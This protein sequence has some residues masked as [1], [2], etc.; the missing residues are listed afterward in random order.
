MNV[1]IGAGISGL[2]AGQELRSDFLILEKSSALGGLAGQYRAG[3]F[4]FDHGGH[5]FHFQDKPEIQRHVE[6]FHAFRRYRRNSK[7][8]L[9]GRFIPYS[10]QY[11]LAG[12]PARQRN[13]ILAEVL[14][15]PGGPAG[16]PAQ[17]L[18]RFL[19]AHFGPSLVRLFFAPYLEK[20]YGR[21]LAAMIAGMDKGSIPVPRKEDVVAGALCRRPCAEGYNPVF[22]YPSGSLQAFIDDYGRP[23]AARIRC[24]EEVVA[25]EPARKLVVTNGGSYRYDSL[26]STMPLN[27]LL[28]IM[29]PPQPFPRKQFHHLSTLVVNAVLARRRRRFH[30]LY[31]PET[32]FPFYRVGYYPAAG[33]VAVYLEKTI[34]AD[35]PLDARQVRREAVFTLKRTGMI[36]GAEE[37]LF[38]DLKRI[39]VS[40]VVFDR[41]WP[42]LVPAALAHLRRQS[43]HSIGRYGSWN[44]TSMA[45]DI[46]LAR[47][48]AGRLNKA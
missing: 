2:S 32:Q 15:G 27:R 35:S 40:Y 23:L 30:W 38:H 11:H 1:I 18:E 7:V 13:P 12:L 22:Y 45:D 20:F 39:P 26:I 25:I 16:G 29:T 14:A 17:D 37:I 9:Q 44:Y 48:T 47:E 8:F 31:L 21:P 19:L 5:Y 6:M 43:I 41:G 3:G 34:A 4:A 33:T 24:R 42:R 36:A 10:L 28:G 46:R